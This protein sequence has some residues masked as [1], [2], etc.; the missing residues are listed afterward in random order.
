M[1]G[2]APAGWWQA[3]NEPVPAPVPGSWAVAGLLAG[4]LEGL[5]DL[6]GDT[7]P[8]GGLQ[9]RLIDPVG[10][11]LHP[12]HGRARVFG[13][14]GRLDL[15]GRVAAEQLLVGP[16]ALGLVDMAAGPPPGRGT[17]GAGLVG[18]TGGVGRI[19]RQRPHQH[20]AHQQPAGG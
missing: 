12:Q 8:V 18:G 16:L 1:V 11:G 5:V 7:L 17:V 20:P 14:R 19:G 13:Q 4:H 10:I 6:D 9:V 15:A 3:L 2:P